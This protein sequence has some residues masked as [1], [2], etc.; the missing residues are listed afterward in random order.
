MPIAGISWQAA[1]EIYE[2]GNTAF[3]SWGMVNERIGA[4]GIQDAFWCA[5]SPGA[6]SYSKKHFQGPYV[7]SSQRA[8]TDAL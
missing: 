2:N 6:M 5:V 1:T 3:P 7:G 8:G 4:N